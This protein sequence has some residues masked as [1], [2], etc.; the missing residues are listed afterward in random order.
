MS[1]TFAK[2][3]SESDQESCNSQCESENRSLESETELES[4]S[5]QESCNSQCNS[6]NGVLSEINLEFSQIINSTHNIKLCLDNNI[7]SLTKLSAY[8][9]SNISFIFNGLVT[10]FSDIIEEFNQI[11]LKNIEEF[12][13]I[14]FGELLINYLNTCT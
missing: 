9:T 5:D 7:E 14:N 11:S 13:N 1:E 8:N 3:E 10:D 6:E 4:E 2:T 12:S